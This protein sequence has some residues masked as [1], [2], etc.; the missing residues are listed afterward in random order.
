MLWCICYEFVILLKFYGFISNELFIIFYMLSFFK[1]NVM[2]NQF[3]FWTQKSNLRLTKKNLII[4]NVV[5]NCRG[6]ISTISYYFIETSSS[7][8]SILIMWHVSWIEWKIMMF[9]VHQME[10][11]FWT[12]FFHQKYEKIERSLIAMYK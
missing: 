6:W 4:F 2:I 12:L 1:M 9:S 10:N 11:A 3:K 7:P 8:I 5:C